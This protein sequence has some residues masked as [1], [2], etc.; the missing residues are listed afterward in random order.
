MVAEMIFGIDLAFIETCSCCVPPV[1]L[2]LTRHL[3]LNRTRCLFFA[4]SF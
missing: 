2:D 3:V 4:L 1:M